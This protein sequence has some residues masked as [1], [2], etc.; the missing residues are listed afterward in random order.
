MVCH[1]VQRFF[2][3]VVVVLEKKAV[4]RYIHTVLLLFHLISKDIHTKILTVHVQFHMA[5]MYRIRQP[6]SLGQLA[7]ISRSH[8]RFVAVFCQKHPILVRCKPQQALLLVKLYL[9]RLLVI[10][11]GCITSAFGTAGCFQ[12]SLSTIADGHGDIPVII[13]AVY[14]QT[15]LNHDAYHRNTFR[16]RIGLRFGNRIRLRL[17]VRLRLLSLLPLRHIIQ[18]AVIHRITGGC[19]KH[20]S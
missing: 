7:H 17:L 3:E 14:R 20:D 12:H 6:H 1:E 9:V 2:P 8:Q 5:V 19:E 18:I 4:I 10:S 13:L 15:I 16:H 11:P